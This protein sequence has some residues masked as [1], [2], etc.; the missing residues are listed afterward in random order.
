MN[1]D[2][3]DDG[4]ILKYIKKIPRREI[5]ASRWDTERWDTERWDKER[6]DKERWDK[7]RRDK[8]RRDKYRYTISIYLYLQIEILIT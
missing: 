2:E 7:E 3:N 6:W 1:S 5:R 8:E 4:N